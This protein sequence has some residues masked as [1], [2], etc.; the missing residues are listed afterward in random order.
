MIVP[1]PLHLMLGLASDFLKAL[2]KLATTI[3]QQIYDRM[4]ELLQSKRIAK[5]AWL[6]SWTG[7]YSLN[8]H[9]KM[10]QGNQIHKLLK[11]NLALQIKNLFP[12]D[13]PDFSK[14]SYYVDLLSALRDVQSCAEAKYLNDEELA[15]LVKILHSTQ[16]GGIIYKELLKNFGLTIP[17]RVRVQKSKLLDWKQASRLSRKNYYPSKNQKLHPKLMF[18]YATFCRLL[19]GFVAGVRP[20]SKGLNTYIKRSMKISFDSNQSRIWKRYIAKL[21]CCKMHETS[22]KIFEASQT[23]CH[24]FVSCD[25]VFEI[26][27][28][29]FLQKS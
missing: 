16:G 4:D 11:M 8:F 17:P 1:S 9:T 5:Q 2:E 25:D 7:I 20:P 15:R 12:N 19:H 23:K 21:L 13:H 14:V 3:D 26:V 27:F 6:Q 28:K 24:I 22:L 29:V 10:F 18:Y